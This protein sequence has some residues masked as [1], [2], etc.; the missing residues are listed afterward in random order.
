MSA[1]AKFTHLDRASARRHLRQLRT[2]SRENKKLLTK[3][4]IYFCIEHG[5][6]HVGHNKLKG[7]QYQSGPTR[8]G[9]P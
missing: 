9:R 8:E 5:G 7:K 3:L 2:S 6:W 4:G 1:C